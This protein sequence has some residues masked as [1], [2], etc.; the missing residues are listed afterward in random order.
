MKAGEKRVA[1]SES[2]DLESPA[3]PSGGEMPMSSPDLT[4]SERQAVGGVLQTPRL[5][6]GPEEAGFEAAIAAIVGARFAM[7]V[8][9]GT[10]GLH[11]L[12][13]AAGL[14]DGDLAITTPFSFIASTNALL[15][16]RVAPL[17]VDVERETGNI[18]PRLVDQAAADLAAGGQAARRWLPPRAS[19]QGEL[20]AIL[21]VDVFGQPA[22]F[23]P[24]RATA[25][26]HGLA[27]IEDSCEALGAF[28]KGRPAG[29]L[30]DA[31]VFGFYPNKQ[32]TTGEGGMVVTDRADWAESVRAMR[33]QGRAPGDTWLEHSYLG[34]NYRLDE[35]SCALG[36]EQMRRFE[37]LLA[38]R[39]QVAIWYGERLAE[40]PGVEVPEPAA[41]TS[42]ISWFVYA[43]RLAADLDRDAVIRKLEKRGI[44]ARPYFKPIHLQ[45]YY[46][47]RFGT[48]LGDFPVAEDLGRRTLALPFS[49]VMAEAQVEQVCQE[50]AAVLA[51]GG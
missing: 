11:L 38:G 19:S 35:M 31:G 26:R 45:P 42:R 28:Y 5:S 33:N 43:V 20:K 40:I 49:G 1:K 51:G 48:R 4:D 2:R 21:A 29:M 41:T 16:E 6:M 50:L 18:D 22:D 36:R 37:S 30:G 24:L 46:I 14:K 39:E 9:S 27:L 12:V 8:S 17:M 13:R 23:D 3:P 44:P 47:E 25:D 7:A 32:I 15:Y 10:A 34:Y